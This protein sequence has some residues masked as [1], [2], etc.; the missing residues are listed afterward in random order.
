MARK[1]RVEYPGAV[2][3]V[4]SR[5]DRREEIFYDDQ[6]RERFLATLDEACAKTN[7]QVDAYCLM[8]NHFHLVLETPQANLVAGMK[9][10][11][12]TYTD[13]FNRRHKLN[14]HL[15]SGR[16][17]ALVVDGSGTDY[18]RTVCDYVHLNPIR[19]RLL[20]DHEPLHSYLWSS[21]RHYLSKPSARPRWLRV[22]RLLGEWRVPKDSAAGRKYFQAAMEERRKLDEP[23]AFKSVRRGWCLGGED[24]RKELLARMHTRMGKRHG[25]SERRESSEQPALRMIEGE[26]ARRRWTGKDLGELAKGHKTKVKIARRL[27]AETTMTWAWIAQKLGMGSPIYAANC[28]RAAS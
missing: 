8:S 10:F 6:D 1:L 27:R 3:H 16:Y 13:R 17:K 24:F 23:D 14:G 4:L 20:P 28:V 22:D 12:G 2:Y 21:Y 19:A 26:L 7:W 18:L 11:F 9:W 15:F 5:G 25:S